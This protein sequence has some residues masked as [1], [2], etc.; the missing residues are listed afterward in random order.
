MSSDD[1]PWSSREGVRYRGI[2]RS[3]RL[4][5][6]TDCV[7]GV[8]AKR[9]KLRRE[10]SA[11]YIASGLFMDASQNLNRRAFGSADRISLGQNS[12]IYSFEGDCLI[13]GCILAKTLGYPIGS[14]SFEGMT[15]AE[16]ISC[17][18]EGISLP[19]FS[20]LL[21]SLVFVCL[22]D[23]WDKQIIMVGQP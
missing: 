18:G 12:Q 11:E 20:V 1:K 22:P 13:D 4:A 5:D 2:G 19:C 3:P 23:L 14:V 17:I 10:V 6:M 8:E 16:T 7:W 9:R 21:H 15:R